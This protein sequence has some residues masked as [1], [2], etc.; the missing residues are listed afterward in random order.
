MLLDC[1]TLLTTNVLL[2]LPEDVDPQIAEEAVDEEITALLEAYER[3]GHHYFGDR[4]TTKP[5]CSA[6]KIHGTQQIEV[7]SCFQNYMLSKKVNTF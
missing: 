7:L 5:M 2:S 4:R 6:V 3:K 1:L